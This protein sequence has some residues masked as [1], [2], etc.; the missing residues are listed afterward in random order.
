MKIKYLFSITLTILMISNGETVML[1]NM[2]GDRY[3]IP[4]DET[5]TIGHIKQK[6][7][8]EIKIPASEIVLPFQGQLFSDDMT[9]TELA[10][11]LGEDSVVK[12]SYVYPFFI[13]KSFVE[14]KNGT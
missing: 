3:D 14:E 4:S 11:K 8:E 10:T 1:K 5:S 7:S 9:L 12:L 6:L 2:T 13:K